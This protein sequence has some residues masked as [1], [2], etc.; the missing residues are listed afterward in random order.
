MNQI[1]NTND[2][3]QNREYV[4]LGCNTI[5]KREVSAAATYTLELKRQDMPTITYQVL[6]CKKC[7]KRLRNYEIYSRVFGGLAAV[8][9]ILAITIW[10]AFY[11]SQIDAYSSLGLYALSFF[12]YWIIKKIS[13]H[14]LF[15]TKRFKIEYA[16]QVNALYNGEL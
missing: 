1:Y 3:I 6:A 2:L 8:L 10:F 4:C 15:K 9:I 12:A 13:W 16:K 11:S 5:H 7:A 14:I